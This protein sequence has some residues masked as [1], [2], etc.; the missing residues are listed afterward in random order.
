VILESA[1]K[2]PIPKNGELLIL[3][4]GTQLPG[5]ALKPKRIAAMTCHS[6]AASRQRL[7]TIIGALFSLAIVGNK[8]PLSAQQTS[9]TELRVQSL[10]TP[11]AVEDI[12]PL[13]SWQMN[14]STHNQK[15]TA[16]Q[17]V[18][19]RESDKKLVWDSRKVESGLSVNIKYAGQ[20]LQPDTAYRWNLTV[21]DA[22]GK[23][24][25]QASRFETGLMDPDIKAWE[26]ARWIGTHE[27][28][29]DATSA[30][31][32]EIATDFQ[33][34]PGSKAASIVFGAND[35]RF[36]SSFLNIENVRG[37]NYVRAELDI[38]GVGSEAG[39]VLNLYRVGYGKNDSPLKPYKTV[40]KALNPDTN[41]NQLITEESKNKV[42]SLSLSVETGNISVQIDGTALQIAAPAAGGRGREAG[43][44][45]QG[46][47][48]Q[49]GQ[50]QGGFGGGGGGGGGGRGRG[51][52]LT[53]SNYSTGNNFNTYPNL[54]S[55]GFASRP[56]DEVLFANFR[57]LN[58]GRSSPD[59]NVVFGPAKGATYS[60]F[61]NLPGVILSSDGSSITVKNDTRDILV[62]HADPSHGSLTMLRTRFATR[63]GKSIARAKMFV[64]AMGAYEV[65][66]NGERMGAD[67]FAPGDS[68]FR[69]TLCYYAYD[70]TKMLRSGGNTLGAI[71]NSGW[72]TGYMTFSPGNLN[73]FG[74]TEAL[75][76][77]LVI[78]YSDGTRET[79]VTDPETWKLYKN[80]PIEYGSFFQGERYNANQ[81]AN[82]SIG[83]NKRGWATNAYDDATWTR[84][85][86][87]KQRDW[88]KFAL[89]ARYDEPVRLVETL[90]AKRVVEGGGH[91]QRG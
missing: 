4:T 52:G 80:G 16:Y 20:A 73:F 50:P 53:I 90:Q 44:P 34:R 40:S 63:A 56:G 10:T 58:K 35:F 75:L 82:I 67:W 68:Q 85:E 77:K 14:S 42:H 28:T 17:I 25:A 26:G 13:F 15:Q 51:G 6:I 18:V 81:E 66:I 83:A 9:I 30:C 48:P 3:S 19:T 1:G 39:A 5:F 61:R 31:L 45:P 24:Y 69:E 54:N 46:A 70:V 59:N 91:P 12:N 47:P 86:I 55:I 22:A 29:L 43:A 11:L 65:Y 60:I 74:D 88:I 27:L 23:T 41:I 49:G 72:Y 64:T 32:Y 21:W 2:A 38:S 78:T 71:L 84:P 36:S 7:L 33:I 8:I 62:G 37:E 87:V 76:A 79:V 89:V 57:I